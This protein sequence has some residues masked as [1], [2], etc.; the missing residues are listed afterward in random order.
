MS[1]LSLFLTRAGGKR[2][3]VSLS[4]LETLPNFMDDPTADYS[5]MS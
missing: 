4:Q 5:G 2:S 1:T 3:I